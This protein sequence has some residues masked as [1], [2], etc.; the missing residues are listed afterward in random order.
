MGKKLWG[1]RGEL[2][3]LTGRPLGHSFS[4]GY[5]AEKFAREGVRAEYVLHEVED[6]DELREFLAAHPEVRGFNVTAPYKQD[7]M[8]LVDALTPQAA[9]AGAVNTVRVEADGR[10]TGHNTDVEGFRHLL[11]VNAGRCGDDVGVIREALLIGGG[12]VAGAVIRALEEEGIAW[13]VAMRCPEKFAVAHPGVDAEPIALSQLGRDDIL[14]AQL[15]VNCTS[16]GTFPDVRSAP[17]IPYEYVGR[18]HLCL[19]LVYNPPVTM[20]MRICG[21]HGAVT[22]NGLEMLVAQAEGAWRFWQG[23]G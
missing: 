23:E 2:Y 22:A 3:F 18:H 9:G 13:R 15:I 19:D 10:L 16:A 5:F 11:G 8:R 21:A 20:F 12:G 17:A 14:R 6:V 7:V 1:E 4:P